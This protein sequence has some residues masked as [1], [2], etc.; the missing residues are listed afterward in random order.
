M[1]K[2]AS[3]LYSVNPD[4]YVG[5]SECRE[6]LFAVPLETARD[7]IQQECKL[8]AKAALRAAGVRFK[9]GA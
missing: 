9:E 8:M 7:D 1:E 6:R 3:A 5:R 4:C 2:A